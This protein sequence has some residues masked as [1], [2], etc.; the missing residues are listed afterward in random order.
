MW[1]CLWSGVRHI[2]KVYCTLSVDHSSVHY[3]GY[4]TVVQIVHLQR[5]A[6]EREDRGQRSANIEVIERSGSGTEALG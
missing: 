1:V 4:D 2:P 6:L 5:D 3:P